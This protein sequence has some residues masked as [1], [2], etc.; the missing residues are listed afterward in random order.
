MGVTTHSLPEARAAVASGAD[1]ISC[2]PVFPS[3]TKPGL[4]PRGLSYL[5]GALTLGVPVV[6]IGGITPANVG[7][8]VRR[9]AR[10]VAVCAAVAGARNIRAAAKAIRRKLP[11]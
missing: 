1:Y 10:C 5:A 11:R 6:C 8:L 4:A 9:G 3:T 2:G 7:G